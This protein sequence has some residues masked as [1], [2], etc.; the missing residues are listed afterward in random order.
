MAGD[1][2]VFLAA[3]D[4]SRETLAMLDVYA[5]QLVKWQA[6]INLVGPDTIPNLWSRHF[7]DSM[8]LLAAMPEAR[9]IVDLGSGAGFPGLV[10]AIALKGIDGAHVT[11]VESNA[12]KV[13]FLRHV[14]QLTGAPARV[15]AMRLEQ[16]LPMLGTV[17]VVTARALA[18]LHQ[19][20]DWCEPLLKTGTIGLFPKGRD[21]DQEMAIA[22][23]YWDVDCEIIPSLVAAGSS[24][25]KIRGLRSSQPR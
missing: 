13:A 17:D 1:R 18:P 25:L 22:A 6:R 2:D 23:R 24:I 4:V 16:A 14:I 12:K 20:L 21:L 8:Q 3:T 11:L 5:D 7:L 10:L 19:L 9:E 15:L